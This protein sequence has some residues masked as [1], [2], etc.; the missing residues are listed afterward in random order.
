MNV[1]TL[2]FDPA[3]AVN[4]TATRDGLTFYMKQHPTRNA[5]RTT[6]PLEICTAE[7]LN[8]N[9]RYVQRSTFCKQEYSTTFTLT[10]GVR[11]K[12]DMAN[13]PMA[14]TWWIG[15][16][17]G[18][19]GSCVCLGLIGGNVNLFII[20]DG[21]PWGNSVGV[22]DRAEFRCEA[23]AIAGECSNC[24]MRHQTL[25]NASYVTV[26]PDGEPINCTGGNCIND[27]VPL[28]LAGSKENVSCETAVTNQSIR[29]VYEVPIFPVAGGFINCIDYCDTNSSWDWNI[30][31]RNVT[32]NDRELAANTLV[33]DGNS[34]LSMRNSNLTVLNNITLLKYNKD[35][36]A[37]SS[38]E[39]GNLTIGKSLYI[40]GNL[41]L[42]RM[43]VTLNGTTDGE[44]YIKVT[45]NGTLY[46]DRS[47]FSQ[48]DTT[49]AQ[50]YLWAIKGANIT[51][52]TAFID[53]AGWGSVG[54]QAGF[55]MDTPKATLQHI[56]MNNSRGIEGS[57]NFTH[58]TITDVNI[59]DSAARG[60]IV[61]NDTNITDLKV[62]NTP[63]SIAAV[64]LI[65]TN[66][67]LEG[68]ILQSAG[69]GLYFDGG[70]NNTATKG[71][72]NNS[73]YGI[74][75]VGGD[76]NNVTST[77]ITG[78]TTYGMSLSSGASNNMHR[79]VLI[80]DST[81]QQLAVVQDGG[82]NIWIDSV[83]SGTATHYQTILGGTNYFHNTSFDKS[84]T[85]FIVFGTLVVSWPI[86]INVTNHIGNP[87]SGAPVN[88]TSPAAVD[89]YSN[90]TDAAGLI[91]Y[92]NVTE[93][94]VTA[95]GRTF[96]GNYT[97][98]ITH[99]SHSDYNASHNYTGPNQTDI[100]LGI[101][102]SGLVDGYQASPVNITAGILTPFFDL[103]YN[104]T[105]ES[106]IMTLFVSLNAQKVTGGGT[107]NI[108]LSVKNDN[109]TLIT[110][111]IRSVSTKFAQGSTGLSI[112]NFTVNAS[113]HTL[114]LLAS[115]DGSGAVEL[116]NIDINL[117]RN[118]S[119]HQ[120]QVFSQ[121][122]QATYTHNQQSYEPA[123]NWTINKSVNSSGAFI[124]R[125]TVFSSVP[126]ILSYYFRDEEGDKDG[127]I[128]WRSI[129]SVTETGS[130]T[131]LFAELEEEQNSLHTI[132]SKISKVGTGT[133]NGTV[134]E[135]SFKDNANYSIGFF[136]IDNNATNISTNQTQGAGSHNLANRTYKTKNGTGLFIQ[137][138]A[139][140]G[141]NSGAQTATLIVN[142]TGGVHPRTC[143]NKKER[144]LKNNADLGN[145][146]GFFTCT[147]LTPGQ[148]YNISLW[149][150]IDA[151][152][153]VEDVDEYLQAWEV[154]AGDAIGT[155]IEIPKYYDWMLA[156]VI[157]FGVSFSILGY[158]VLPWRKREDKDYDGKK[159]NY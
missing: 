76:Y 73:G 46:I 90:S 105:N 45:T 153:S 21:L 96:Y 78:S 81:I 14:Y 123:F 99:L 34:T 109:E 38:W 18:G 49:A 91:R 67:H 122:T 5:R 6:E 75:N 68:Y 23:T 79:H 130:M 59:S 83:I 132:M 154:N 41:T 156:V 139:T 9:S 84:K 100:I 157:L 104:T 102:T 13:W 74:Q 94:E 159:E 57:L 120:N 111:T 3:M 53:W 106:S 89:N 118:Y 51:I 55:Y 20:P 26:P 108:V 133:V 8:R 48:G 47:N 82:T 22:D 42:E 35:P 31:N 119:V 129:T 4:W 54:V 43:R 61:Y 86:S 126:S 33:V 127:P 19:G 103:E 148:P 16:G 143:S 121:I 60:I 70:Q 97:I 50:W 11:N 107:N 24:N 98:N 113:N 125:W 12:I 138:G 77:N 63:S 80:N 158:Y 15:E 115:R 146:F 124:G 147:N 117:A 155:D 150:E 151:G 10:Y 32:C 93:M 128:W 39:N 142:A 72:I 145:V 66:S 28:G 135:T 69:F 25:I 140:M 136:A 95:A 36:D 27:N 134:Y 141:S 137:Y 144:Y 44:S 85:A 65:G 116:S 7:P 87:V 2:E 37:N 110:E 131:A 17:K 52:D 58:A 112:I 152:E 88:I 40:E 71:T 30:T 1:F 101:K 149:I 56:T 114:Q 64:R 92:L 62:I 29:C